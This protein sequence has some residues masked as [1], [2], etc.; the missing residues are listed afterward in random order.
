MFNYQRERFF[1]MPDYVLSNERVK[2][3]VIGKVLDIEFA[4]VLARN[5]TLSLGQIIM[6]DKVQKKKVISDT[7]IDHL[8]SK[9]LI[10]GRKPNFHISSDVAAKT[11][12]QADYVKT[13]GLKDDYF[14]KLILEYLDKYKQASKEDIDK[15]LLDILPG[16]LDEQQRRNKIRNLVYAMSKKD[17]TIKNQGTNRYPKWT[18][19]R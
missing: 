2:V 14:K 10:E 15:L 19:V 4:R 8:R 7:E 11:N 12:L 13:R 9:G 17:K 5:P 6:L 3:T 1:P 18:R 16:V